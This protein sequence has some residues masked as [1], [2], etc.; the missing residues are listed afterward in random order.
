MSRFFLWPAASVCAR[1]L[2]CSPLVY[3]AIFICVASYCIAH[4]WLL[5]L[6]NCDISIRSVVSL[7]L[8]LFLFSATLKRFPFLLTRHV[9]CLL[10]CVFE[11]IPSK[12]P[13]ALLMYWLDWLARRVLHPTLDMPTVRWQTFDIR[14]WNFKWGTNK[15]MTFVFYLINLFVWLSLTNCMLFVLYCLVLWF[16]IIQ[17]VAKWIN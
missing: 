2:P 10:E 16:S 6:I 15:T 11:W 12:V 8:S 1:H 7:S 14:N 9:E 4:Y 13:V 17:I 5:H 3:T